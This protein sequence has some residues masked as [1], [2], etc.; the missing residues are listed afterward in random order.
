[1]GMSYSSGFVF[2]SKG[3]K[4]WR[5]AID[6]TDEDGATKRLVRTSSVPCGPDT[7]RDDGTVKQNARGKATAE[8]ALRTWRD[9]LVAKSSEGV[10]SETAFHEYAKD[11]VAKKE[12]MRSVSH[13]TVL[14]YTGM[15]RQLNGT[16]LGRSPI[17]RITADMITEFIEGMLED[18]LSTTTVNKTHVFLK[19]VCRDKLQGAAGAPP[20]NPRRTAARGCSQFRS[21]EHLRGDNEPP[22]EAR[23]VPISHGVVLLFHGEELVARDLLHSYDECFITE[24]FLYSWHH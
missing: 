14:G 5:M 24:D 7:V 1:M 6:Q 11:Y 3:S 22:G 20:R 15:L 9:E 17:S 10:W 21:P 23:L 12:R 18:G 19:S 4:H 8:Q 16:R 13:T 2:K